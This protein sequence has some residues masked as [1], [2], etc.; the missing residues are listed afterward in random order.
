MKW[1][2][3]TVAGESLPPLNGCFMVFMFCSISV[4]DL[5]RWLI[6]VNAKALANRS[7]QIF[8]VSGVLHV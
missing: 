6:R 3:Q 2:V 5:R 7:K 8:Q 1:I 4:A